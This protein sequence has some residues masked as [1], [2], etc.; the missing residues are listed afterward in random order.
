MSQ[1]KCLKPTL[2]LCAQNLIEELKFADK[3]LL[4]VRGLRPA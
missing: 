1:K 2:V 3:E 4:F